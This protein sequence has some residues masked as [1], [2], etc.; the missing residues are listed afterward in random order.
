MCK[1]RHPRP[2]VSS[3]SDS[4]LI[5]RSHI[6]ASYTLESICRMSPL[7]SILIHFQILYVSVHAICAG[8]GVARIDTTAF[9]AS[10]PLFHCFTRSI[11]PAGKCTANDDLEFVRQL[12]SSMRRLKPLESYVLATPSHHSFANRN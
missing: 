8:R 11:D 12:L 3:L 10:S 5:S 4:F 6:I 1:K 2:K 7:P 9:P